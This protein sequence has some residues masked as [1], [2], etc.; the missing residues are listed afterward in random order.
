MRADNK[1]HN[2]R[3]V[4]WFTSMAMLLTVAFILDLFLGSVDLKLSDVIKA[5]FHDAGSTVETIVF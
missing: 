1:L 2:N 5:L 3:Y 4:Y